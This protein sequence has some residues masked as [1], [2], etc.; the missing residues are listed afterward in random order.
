MISGYVRNE[1]ALRHPVI[2]CTLF[3]EIEY[4]F[5]HFRRLENCKSV[6]Q[7]LNPF[8]CPNRLSVWTRY[9]YAVNY[10]SGKT[11]EVESRVK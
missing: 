1:S 5:Q 3:Y 6:Q 10:F 9:D 2:G 7:A 8:F 4:I 11:E